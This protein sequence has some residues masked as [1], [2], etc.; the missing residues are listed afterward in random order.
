MLGQVEE[1]R[2]TGPRPGGSFVVTPLL[3]R[4]LPHGLGEQTLL[5]FQERGVPLGMAD[6]AVSFAAM[7]STLT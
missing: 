5:I 1:I 4:H 7:T 3:R 6:S 2:A